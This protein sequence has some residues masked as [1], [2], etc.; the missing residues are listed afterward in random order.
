MGFT[1]LPCY[2]VAL[3]NDCC[4]CQ[5]SNSHPDGV[6]WPG[7]RE[8]TDDPPLHTAAGT[9]G[10]S[11]CQA[12]HWWRHQGHDTL[13]QRMEAGEPVALCIMKF[14]E[15]QRCPDIWTSTKNELNL[16]WPPASQHCMI[17]E[18]DL[19]TETSLNLEVQFKD[20]FLMLQYIEDMQ[21][22]L[23]MNNHNG[24]L[25]QMTMLCRIR[26]RPLLHC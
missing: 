21:R 26:H 17:L 12:T 8:A 16:F 7:G 10:F 22:K 14:Q 6:L 5:V 24:L 25:M 13:W 3:G 11:G 19:F 4:L 18:H 9:G 2:K 1:P 20:F 23:E 15:L